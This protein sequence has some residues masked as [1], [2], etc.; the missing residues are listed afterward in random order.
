MSVNLASTAQLTR[1]WGL[2]ARAAHWGMSPG[3]WLVGDMPELPYY[4]CSPVFSGADSC[5]TVGTIGLSCQ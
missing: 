2:K 1:V 3:L 4:A 5:E